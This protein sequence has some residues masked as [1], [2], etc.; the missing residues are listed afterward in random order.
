M[1]KLVLGIV[2]LAVMPIGCNPDVPPISADVVNN[3]LVTL[4][5]LEWERT[6]S[7]ELLGPVPHEGWD[8]PKDGI[9]VSSKNKHHHYES[10]ICLKTTYTTK[11]PKM[12]MGSCKRSVEH[13]WYDYTLVEWHKVRELKTTG[14]GTVEPHWPEPGLGENERVRELRYEAY[15]ASFRNV[16]KVDTKV[17]PFTCSNQAEWAKFKP[18]HSYKA[19]FDTNEHLQQVYG[20]EFAE[21]E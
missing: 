19:R 11:G 5:R 12:G 18:G 7:V 14:D 3:K 6:M 8:V 13:E 1:K 4:D 15:R 20:A 16:K 9:V 21:I 10:Y 2:A 17:Y